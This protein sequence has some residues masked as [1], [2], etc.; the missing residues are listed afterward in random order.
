MNQIAKSKGNENHRRNY[1]LNNNNKQRRKKNTQNVYKNI[2]INTC[3]LSRTLFIIVFSCVLGILLY[4]P[5]EKFTYS[6]IFKTKQNKIEKW[7]Y[8]EYDDPNSEATKS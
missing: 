3:V 1:H 4:L 8:F 5:K 6:T 2:I 7:N